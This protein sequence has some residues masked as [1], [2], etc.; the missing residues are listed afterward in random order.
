MTL[1]IR[2]PSEREWA[3]WFDRPFGEFPTFWKDFIDTGLVRI[4]QFEKDDA[5]VVRA[6]LPG[7]DPEKDVEVTVSRGRLH[8]RAERRS[9]TTE[10][11]AK[12]YRSE[13]VYGVFERTLRLPAGASADEVTATYRDGILEV[14]VP[15]VPEPDAKRVP[16]DN[17]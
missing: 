7:L 12:G 14:T 11:T 4:E 17:K 5:L 8:I 3:T 13:F 15:I 6:E 9:D 2:S 10:E 1:A 16:I